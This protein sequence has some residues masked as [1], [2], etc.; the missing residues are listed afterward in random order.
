[1]HL[2]F[3]A[4]LINLKRFEEAIVCFDKAIELNPNDIEALNNKGASL[5]YLKRHDEAI[6]C[7]NKCLELDSNHSEALFNKG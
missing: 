4:C 5:D 6:E 1:M 2:L 3:R 7:F